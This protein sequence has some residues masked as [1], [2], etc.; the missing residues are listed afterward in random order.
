M[1]N[2]LDT[3]RLEFRPNSEPTIVGT[4]E[5]EGTLDENTAEK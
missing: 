2:R 1:K 4:R 3:V 5:L